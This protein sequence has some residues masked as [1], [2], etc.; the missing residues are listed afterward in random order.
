M[1]IPPLVTL[2]A[3][4]ITISEAAGTATITIQLENGAGQPQISGKDVTVNLA[5]SGL[6][7]AGTDYTGTVTQVIIPAGQTSRTIVLTAVS[8]SLNEFDEDIVIDI[9]TAINATESGIQQAVV[10][11]TDDDP[12]PELSISAS[13]S[14]IAETGGSSVISLTLSAPSGR[15]IDVILTASGTASLSDY[16]IPGLTVTIPAGQTQATVVLSATTDALDEFDETVVLDISPATQFAAISATAASTTVTILDD[17]PLPTA[18]LSVNRTLIAENADTAVLTVTLSAVSG[19]DVT[20]DLGTAGTAIPGT[21]YV[22]SATQIVVPAGSLSGQV[23]LTSQDDV[24]DEFSETATVSISAAQHANIGGAPVTVTITDDDPTPTVSLTVDSTVVPET[25]GPATFTVSTSAA[26]GRDIVVNLQQTGSATP[27]ADSTGVVSQVTLPAGTL[28]FSFTVNITDD[29]LDEPDETLTLNILTVQNGISDGL[30]R[31]VTIT[32]DDVPTLTLTLADAVVNEADGTAATTVTIRRNTSTS[33]SLPVTLTSSDPGEATIQSTIVIPAGQSSVTVPVNA[34][35]DA[36][37]DGTQTVT[38]TAV[39]AG[40][41][42]GTALLDVEDATTAVNLSVS[43]QAASETGTTVV[44]LTATTDKPVI[45]NQTVDLAVSGSGITAQ[46]YVL[47]SSRLTFLNGQSVAT[48]TFTVRD[49]AVVELLNEIATITLTSPTTG[50]AVGPT[51]SQTVTITDNDAARL[52]IG[53]VTVAEGSQ[54]TSM[55]VFTVTLDVAVESAFTFSYATADGTATTADADYTA[56][57]G[58]AGFT[59]AAGETVTISVPLSPDLKVELD[60]TLHLDLS[61]IAAGGRNVTFAN[62]R[63]TATITNDDSASI[64]IADLADVEGDSGTTSFTI[65]VTLDAPVAAPVTVTWGTAGDTAAATADFVSGSGNLTFAANTAG[66]QSLTFVVDVVGDQQVELDESFFANL[67]NAVTSGL[68]VSISDAQ[69][70]IDI[71]NDDL[72][73]LSIDDISIAEGNSGTTDVTLTVTLNSAVDTPLTVNFDTSN[74]TAQFGEDYIPSTGSQLTFAGQAGEQRTITIRTNGDRRVETDETF[75]VTLSNIAA[76]GRLVGLVK[77]VG[78]VTLQNDDSAAITINDATITEGDSGTKN[79]VFT[80][81]LDGE[82]S[83]PVTLNAATSAI[84]ASDSDGDYVSVNGPLTFAANTGGP[85]SLT[86]TVP[87]N[88]D[89]KVEQT[90]TFALDLT[91]LQNGGLSVTLADAQGLGTITNDDQATISITD[92]SRTEG[93]SGTTLFVFDVSLD[94]AVGAPV[95]VDFATADGTA[96]TASGDY[97]AASG[98]ALTF[99]ANT[100]GAQVQTITIEVGA[101]EVV[102]LNESFLVNLLNLNAGGLGVTLNR[103]TAVGTIQNDDQAHLSIGDVSLTEGDSGDSLIT[104]TVSM[105]AAVDAPVTVNYSTS[106]GTATAGSGD[107]TAIA[108]T[109]LT[110]TA[111]TAAPQTQT[112]QVTIRGDQRVEL[113]ETFFARL[114]TLAASGRNVVLG[115][116]EAIG[117]ILN[118]DSASVS[119]GDVTLSEGSAGTTIFAFVVTL[120]QEVDVPVRL[121]FATADDTATAADGD[122]TALSGQVVTF[123]ENAG[124]GPQTQT[125]SVQVAGDARLEPTESFFL[126]LSNLQAAGR[127]VTLT[128]AQGTGTIVN[129]DAAAISIGDVTFT[130]GDAGQRTMNFVVT[131]LAEVTSDVS[132]DFHVSDGSAVAGLDYIAVPD[133]TLTFAGGPGTGI[134]TRTISIPIIGDRIVELDETIQVT[135]SGIND[136]GQGVTLADAVG[137]GTISNDDTATLTIANVAVNEGGSLT[138]SVTLDRAVDAGLSLSYAAQDETATIANNDY[139]PEPGN[140][141][142]FTGQAGEVRN[143][144]V[145]TTNDAT[146]ELNETFLINLSGLQAAGRNVVLGNTFAR[147]TINNNDTATISI[148]DVTITEGNSGTRQAAFTVQ[149]TGSVD[150]PVSVDFQTADGTA[151]ASSG[152]YTAASGTLTFSGALN[153]SITQNVTVNGDT[154]VEAD[155]TFFVNLPGLNVSGRAVTISDNRAQGTITNDDQVNVSVTGASVTEG[156]QSSGTSLVFTITRDNNSVPAVITYSTADGTATAGTDYVATSGSITLDAN[157]PMTQTISVPVIGDH[158]SENAETV[159][160]NIASTTTG[161]VITTPQASASILNDD[162]FVTGQ[163]WY[164]QNGNGIHDSGEPGLNGW[165]IQIVTADGTVITSGTTRNI[166]LNG[167]GTIDPVTEAGQYSIP[168]NRGTWNVQEVLKTGWRQSFPDGGNALAHRIDVDNNLEFTGNLFENWGGLGE[169]WLRGGS[170]WYFITPAGN[171]YRWD[172][173][174]RTALTGDFLGAVGGRFHANPSLLY[175]STPSSVTTVTV[176]TAQTVSGINFGNIPTGRIEGRKFLDVDADRFRDASEPWLNGWTITLTDQSGNVVGTTVTQNLDRNGNGTIEGSEIGWYRFDNLLPG[177]YTVSEESRPGWVQ[178]GVDGL[179]AAEAYRLDQDVNF[180]QPKNEFLNWG[181][182]N[183]RWLFSDAGWHFI[184]PDGKLYKWDKSPKTALT[185]TLVATLDPTYWQ[186]LSL[187]YDAQPATQRQIRITGQEV[188]DVNFGNTFGHNDSGTGNVTTQVS[189]GSLV[190]TGDAGANSVVVHTLNGTTWVTG[191]GNTTVNGQS[192]PVSATGITG[193]VI[194][195]GDGNDQLVVID[196]TLTSTGDA[197]RIDSG[198]GQDRVS[199][200]HLTTPG[201]VSIVNAGATDL[202]RIQDSAVRNLT[203]SG[204]RVSVENSHINGTLS[205]TSATATTTVIVGTEIVGAATFQGSALADTFLLHSSVFHGAVNV[206]GNAGN[207]VLALVSGDFRVAVSVNGDADNDVL[208][209]RKSNRFGSTAAVSGGNGTDTLATDGTTT[210]A[211]ISRTET[212]NNSVLNSLIDQALSNFDGLQLDF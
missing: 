48:A 36:L 200:N 59:G 30:A 34:I 174:P 173:S 93:S 27:L 72:A 79:L 161:V 58:Q 56:T 110:F 126:N 208:G 39:S 113:D 189:N 50:L 9:A 7:I 152:D 29:D 193:A 178:S 163:K 2:S 91:A 183:E 190:V 103:S 75:F 195:L 123:S 109:G 71:L 6:A 160:L 127:N 210:G 35:N 89:T 129:D 5:M 149:L 90:E 122:F 166:D 12:L 84:T 175:N 120:D 140:L 206:R 125:I 44:T 54:G 64:T 186:N 170:K 107:Y 115:D 118:D 204:G 209:L 112:F 19:R 8:D 171:V 94:R 26:S 68:N 158:I 78:T 211:Q 142:T 205:E 69:A 146:V 135:L 201:S 88:G 148:T 98:T 130:E 177:V 45:G 18:S 74:G 95:T 61:S 105:D 136:G 20:I 47:S 116:A 87:I 24:L 99:A 46:D 96:T 202:I 139:S 159:F 128:D 182:R 131:L 117:T 43:T 164:D 83:V 14:N 150:I 165:V 22:L 80:V 85:Q 141:L 132:V 28:T 153:Q 169:K 194:S 86:V 181:G 155:E 51:A 168:I 41:A 15:D 143:I 76:S 111:G 124:P 63:G 3:A 77:D 203:L 37:L 176:Q 167:D 162:G 32:D 97:T 104:F 187:L 192:A 106:D 11:I 33:V 92:V 42:D 198:T 207:D 151:S 100:P 172:G 197:L 16:S 38:L 65:T 81:T 137:I 157:G 25:G 114:T 145:Q 154:L 52:S 23:T 179:F 196:T 184:T 108:P 70:T 191:V 17:D 138:F 188:S 67:S 66:P 53:N 212:N 102:E 156:Y 13:G 101:D 10:T 55:A 4:P 121:D 1:P 40:F 62:T 180:R 73:T 134:Q 147:G 199:V 57:T 82:V 49:D 21:D 60:E 31:T 119:I 185:G 144:I 133:G